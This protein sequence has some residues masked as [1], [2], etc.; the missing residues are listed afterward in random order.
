MGVEPDAAGGEASF[1]GESFSTP[2]AL[3]FGFYDHGVRNV[4]HTR[5]IDLV[6]VLAH[7]LFVVYLSRIRFSPR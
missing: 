7:R 2:S 5:P 6:S 3:F 4:D 1:N